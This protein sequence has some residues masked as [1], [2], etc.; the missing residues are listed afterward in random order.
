MYIVCLCAC[1]CCRY[2]HLCMCLWKLRSVLGIFCP[3]SVY[4]WS[5]RQCLLLTLVLSDWV[6][7]WESSRDLSL[8]L[9]L[10]QAHAAAPRPLSNAWIGPQLLM[11]ALLVLQPLSS[12]SHLHS[13]HS[14]TFALLELPFISLITVFYFIQNQHQCFSSN[15]EAQLV[16]FLRVL[17]LQ[18]HLVLTLPL[19]SATFYFF[20]THLNCGRF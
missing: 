5:L 1:V 18:G 14:C 8:T 2:I 7:W 4:M 12:L 11:H 17:P 3:L 19:Y 15:M 9:Q 13:S 16:L 20:L 6:D 10:S